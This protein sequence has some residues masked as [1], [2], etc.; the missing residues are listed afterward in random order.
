M[1][2][3][4]YE[5]TVNKWGIAKGISV[6]TFAGLFLFY[7]FTLGV[8]DITGYSGDQICAG[9]EADP[10]Y[11]YINLTA[12]EDIFIYPIGYDPWGRDTPFEFEPGVESWKFQRSWGNYWKDIPLDK[13]CTGTWCGAPNN[14]GVKYSYVLREGRDYQFRIVG[15]KKDPTEDIKWS[16][17]YENREYLDPIWF[18][19]QGEIFDSDANI[20]TIR[21]EDITIE[22]PMD[23]KC[24]WTDPDADWKLCEVVLAITNHDLTNDFIEKDSMMSNFKH[25]IMEMEVYTSKLANT[26]Q[27]KIV[28]SECYDQIDFSKNVPLIDSGLSNKKLATEEEEKDC[29][30][31]VTKYE[32]NDWKL[33][34]KLDKFPKGDT[35]GVKLVFKSPILVDAG[36]YLENQ[37]NFS[38]FGD[39]NVTLD[40]DISACTVLSANN[41]VYTMTGSIS[42]SG[43]G[44]CMDVT[45]YNVTLDCAGETIDGDGAADT[46][47]RV[48]RASQEFVNF[49][50][51]NCILTDWD[52]YSMYVIYATNVTFDNITAASLDRGLWARYAD[53]LVIK[54]SDITGDGGSSY[55]VIE[56]RDSFDVVIEDTVLTGED[57]VDGD[58]LIIDAS[59]G[60]FT[61]VNLTWSSGA[62]TD[63]DYQA[64]NSGDC[65]SSFTNVL[66]AE[67]LPVMFYNSQVTLEHWDNNMSAIILCNAD[68]SVLN[69]MTW[70]QSA[71]TFGMGLVVTGDT[72]NLM[73]ANST[74][75]NLNKAMLL[76][77][78]GSGL[79]LDNVRVDSTD[80]YNIQ[81]YRVDD[82][83]TV[84]KNSYFEGDPDS[85]DLIY[86]LYP[87]SWTMYNNTFQGP[88]YQYSSYINLA[89]PGSNNLVYN[90]LFN[91]SNDDLGYFISGG[92]AWNIA[93]QAGDRVYGEGVNIGGNYYNDYSGTGFSEDCTDADQ[94]GFCDSSFVDAQSSAVDA[95]PL[96]NKYSP[97]PPPVSILSYPANAYSSD[98]AEIEF[99]CNGTDTPQLANVTWYVWNS[100]DDEINSST[101]DWTGTSN[102]STFTHDFTVYD[103]Y[104]WNCLVVDNQSKSDWDTNRTLSIVSLELDIL[105]PT[106][107][108]PESV[109]SL[110]N[111]TLTFLFLENGANLTT[112]VTLNNITIDDVQANVVEGTGGDSF[113]YYDDF[114]TDFGHWAVHAGVNCPDADA[115]GDR[116]TATGSS[117]TGPQNGGVGGAGTY[118]IFVETSSG[119]CY[120]A[121]DVALVYLNETI[122]Y[123]SSSNE[124]I[125]FYF[126]AYGTEIDT[127]YLEENS[128]GSW[129]SLWSMSDINNDYWNL[130]S[131]DLSSLT[132]SGNLRFNYTRTSTG[133]L[134][135]IAL[136]RINVTGSGGGDEFGWIE[137]VGWQ[138][139][140]TVPS[141]G[142]GYKDL[143]INA[144][145]GGDVTDTESNAILYG[146][147]DDEYPQFSNYWD[148]NASLIDSGD[149][150]FN[151]TVT[152]TNGTVLLEIDGNN[153]TAT[154]LTADIYN[155]TY[156]FSSSGVYP[157]RWHSWGNGSAANYNVSIDQSYTVNASASYLDWSLNQT[158][159]TVAGENILF[160]VFWETSSDLSSYI[161]GWYNGANWTQTNYSGDKEAG[162][163]TFSG[164]GGAGGENISGKTS[165]G[166]TNGYYVNNYPTGQSITA[167]MSGD[168][169]KASVW[170][171]TVNSANDCKVAIYDQSNNLIGNTTETNVDQAG[172]FNFTFGAGAT[173]TKD[174]VYDLVAMCGGSSTQ[175][176]LGYE[177]LG[178]TWQYDSYT[179]G[180]WMEPGELNPSSGR[181]HSMY[182]VV[183]EGGGTSEDVNKTAVDY[184]N[185]FAGSV[186]SQIDNIT[187]TVGVS[188]YN[189]SG[190]IANANDNATLWLEVWDGEGWESFGE[191]FVVNQSGNFSLVVTTSMILA[192]WQTDADR[193]LRISARLMDYNSSSL[194]DTINWTGTWIDIESQQEFLNDSA[195]EFSGSTNHSNVTKQITSSVGATIKWYVWANSSDAENMTDIFQFITTSVIINPPNVTINSPENIT[196]NV[197]EIL[198]NI[199]AVDDGEVDSCWMSLDDGNNISMENILG[200]EIG[201]IS[202]T[203]YTGESLS[204]GSGVSNFHFSSDGLLLYTSDTTLDI[205]AESSCSTPWNLSSCVYDTSKNIS[206]GI[207]DDPG[208]L[209]GLDMK[210]DGTSFYL[211]DWYDK[212]LHQFDCTDA[213]NISSCSYDGKN[214]SLS[215]DPGWTAKIHFKPDGSRFYISGDSYDIY[216]YDCSDPWNVSSCVID[217]DYLDI[218]Y[219]TYNMYFINDGTEFISVPFQGDLRQHNCSDAWNV[220]SCVFDGSE[221]TPQ[222]DQQRGVDIDEGTAKLY[223]LG[224]VSDNIYEYNLSFSSGGNTD[225]WVYTNSSMTNGSHIVDFY[226][227]DTLGNLND[228]ES[229]TFSISLGAGDTCSC[230]GSGNNWEVDMEDTCTLS[231]PCNLGTGNLSWI[232]SSG[233]FT[234]NAQ[235]NLTTRDAPISNTV[236]WWS[237]GCEVLRLIFLIFIPATIFKRKRRLDIRWK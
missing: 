226:C 231:T 90:N 179:Y 178:G 194:F 78:P 236:F 23:I 96:S 142:N 87:S 170:F 157:Y 131:V 117:G 218:A 158:N 161:F 116:G 60:D 43:T 222:D 22:A 49:T 45:G 147:A 81:G 97:N 174:T 193:D 136:D 180:A 118:F 70:D 228:S 203:A 63:V 41:S 57:G 138:V 100:T 234:C 196:Y 28:D 156:T 114:E 214:I 106:E 84:I 48:N 99:E 185:V 18:G 102:S 74:M 55:G 40:P 14:K 124:K 65:D 115:W 50:A 215:D 225:D 201:N 149:G 39:Y 111:I 223:T 143:F 1:A 224:A 221:Y 33:K 21:I 73:F 71:N 126:D 88:K 94:D 79:T 17:D 4:V 176:Y 125:E 220:S 119:N 113:E 171:R 191:D 9:T 86:A 54:N 37:F 13:T 154:N 216:Q 52:S 3:K 133:Y 150:H 26:R 82:G 162:T 64:A 148:D 145:N 58:V 140:V 92:N 35:L 186:Y 32:F 34:T 134:S 210:I 181:D 190:S 77:Y 184:L 104:K 103:D 151:V 139:N 177:D 16:V 36:T 93:E 219:D 12:N 144:T 213:W 107:G 38:I 51:K 207:I 237:S 46:A 205:I 44:N 204:V 95:L 129:V 24:D 152:S 31:N 6:G 19:V 209:Q 137:G 192:A 182:W 189:T 101:I 56:F 2:K 42:N 202:D 206:I 108:D 173:V 66:G 68:N 112:G 197:S 183:D 121:G 123:D 8:I 122:D 69:N 59:Y 132:G 217:S 232:G 235:L 153:I 47:I 5:Q 160:S 11:A 198:F 167:Q 127:L 208:V 20:K 141:L 67:G 172:W 155:A 169:T 76:W 15:Y 212:F 10:C 105:D 7:L 120:D 159:S 62:F 25:A 61:N 89:S 80:S 195:V 109:S 200:T 91:H 165:T 130:T 229:V 135:D 30:Y 211:T 110:D 187:V 27:E 168:A 175:N 163:Q 29:E 85:R 166:T 72:D 128:T 164:E 188:Y 98:V 230:P 146:D 53:N 233:S 227:N 83:G 199:T 75:N